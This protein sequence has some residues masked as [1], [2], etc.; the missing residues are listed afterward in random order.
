MLM[1]MESGELAANLI[2]EYLATSPRAPTL[3]DLRANYRAA[4]NLRFGSR[5]KICSWMRRAAFVPG[6]ADWAI[7]L[8]G[9]SDRIRR[10]VTRATRGSRPETYALSERLSNGD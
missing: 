7:R 8:F 9:A 6:L 5:L 1:A 4:Y 2:G 10:R 3:C